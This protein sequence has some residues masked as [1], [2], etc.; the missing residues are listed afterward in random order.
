MTSHILANV[1]MYLLSQAATRYCVMY[2]GINQK[3]GCRF[4]EIGI[5]IKKT[6]IENLT[7]E[8]YFMDYH[9]TF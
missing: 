2:F 7:C 5:Y 1:K 8:L 6:D 4:L 3:K 9:F